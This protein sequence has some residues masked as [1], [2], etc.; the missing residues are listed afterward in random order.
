V[1]AEEVRRVEAEQL[2]LRQARLAPYQQARAAFTAALD[3]HQ[4][5]HA[6]GMIPQLVELSR[7]LAAVRGT[8]LSAEQLTQEV[9]AGVRFGTCSA[10]TFNLDCNERAVQDLCVTH[11]GVNVAGLPVVVRVPSG[12]LVRGVTGSDGRA[13]IELPSPSLP[14][15]YPLLA[16]PDFDHCLGIALRFSLEVSGK[17]KSFSDGRFHDFIEKREVGSADP[18]RF[19]TRELA[20]QAALT[21]ARHLAMARLLEANAGMA[22]TTQSI[23]ATAKDGESMTENRISGHVEALVVRES[24]E[25]R[26][27]RPVAEVVMKASSSY[28]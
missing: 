21:A 1:P 5:A 22:V 26:N 28:Q 19:G 17:R 11:R 16:R 20:E 6:L 25:W 18:S 9:L 12:A 14:G 7:E 2:A 27:G 4:L 8:P 23:H 24:V 13:K 15:Y 3:A 10:T